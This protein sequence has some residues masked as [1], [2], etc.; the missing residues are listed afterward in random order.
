MV[1]IGSS[2]M[3]LDQVASNCV[4]PDQVGLNWF[5]LI[6]LVPVGSNYIKIVIIGLNW[7]KLS[8]ASF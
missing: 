3:E 4:K 2:W 1:Q 7:F 6:K 5:T 8:E